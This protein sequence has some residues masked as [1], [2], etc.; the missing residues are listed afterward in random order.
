SWETGQAM[1]RLVFA[2]LLMQ[3]G[4]V[5]TPAQSRQVEDILTL[6]S[7]GPAKGSEAAPITIIEF[8]DF[9]C[10]YCRKF[11][12][13]TLPR[14]EAEYVKP[15]KIRFVY[16]HLAILGEQSVSAGQAAECARDQGKFWE[17]HDKLFASQRPFAFT[18]GNLKHYA[19]EL[20][21]DTVA[22]NQC[23]DSGKYSQ[24]VDA[25]TG[26]GSTLGLRATPSFFINGRPLIGAHPFETFQLVIEEE[27]E[28]MKSAKKPS[29][30]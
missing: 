6:L 20:G 26:L 10:S 1:K 27:L 25:E 24:R 18:M 17:Y 19:K 13:E 22:F 16:R 8:S 11:W 23:L 3:L 7:Q 21:L 9:Q 15:G 28:K 30:R 4:V 12:K 5:E 29:R 2:I 14:L